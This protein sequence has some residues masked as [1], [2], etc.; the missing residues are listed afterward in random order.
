LISRPHV[1]LRVIAA[2]RADGDVSDKENASVRPD[3]LWRLDVVHIRVPPLRDRPDDV[4]HI[5]RLF[6]AQ[7]ATAAS[8]LLTGF[9]AAAEV[10]LKASKLPGNG[11]ELRR[12]VERAVTLAEGPQVELH[13]I[14]VA[15][16]PLPEPIDLKAAVEEAE[17][18]AILA[19][20]ARCD[21]A[22]GKAADLLGISRK[23]LWE[24]MRRHAIE[25]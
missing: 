19:A 20:L 9:S 14:E 7:A 3:L 23:N 6:L 25:R 1:N 5:A 16:E 2:R 10:Y 22:I 15:P 11:R 24:K 17:R 18:T 8:K 12:M 13:H 21:G 4:V